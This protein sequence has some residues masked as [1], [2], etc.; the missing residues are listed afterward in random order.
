MSNFLRFIMIFNLGYWTGI[1][2]TT[3][4]HSCPSPHTRQ[5]LKPSVELVQTM[6][7]DCGESLDVDG[8]A[9]KKT[10]TAWMFHS[11]G[12]QAENEEIRVLGE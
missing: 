7:N 8:L 9:G 12:W 10:V 1:G 2:W 11:T 3:Y 5:T 4:R 6:L